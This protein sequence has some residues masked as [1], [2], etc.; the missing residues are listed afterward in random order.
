MGSPDVQIE[1]SADEISSPSLISHRAEPVEH[2]GSTF[3]H[4]RHGA[5]QAFV[6]PQGLEIG[7]GNR[8][9]RG[10]FPENP[11]R[12]RCSSV[13]SSGRRSGHRHDDAERAFGCASRAAWKKAWCR[14]LGL[15]EKTRDQRTVIEAGKSRNPLHLSKPFDGGSASSFEAAA[16][17]RACPQKGCRENPQLF[18]R[19]PT[20]FEARAAT[21]KKRPSRIHP[22][23]AGPAVRAVAG[24]ALQNPPR[25]ARRA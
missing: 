4:T 22:R 8:V 16:G 20:L 1:F 14:D 24:I 19:R 13:R 11:H 17:H 3:V 25:R 18:G 9:T 12:R 15:T 5:G 23:R 10:R 7:M 6:I 21:A 2:F